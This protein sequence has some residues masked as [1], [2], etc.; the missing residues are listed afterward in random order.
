MDFF[1]FGPRYSHTEP[2]QCSKA[3]MA[4]G[5]RVPADGSVASWLCPSGLWFVPLTGHAMSQL[6][7]CFAAGNYEAFLNS[8]FFVFTF[9]LLRVGV[10]RI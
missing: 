8:G 4:D 6:W 1:H 3:C 10:F 7:A 5:A 2:A 9:G